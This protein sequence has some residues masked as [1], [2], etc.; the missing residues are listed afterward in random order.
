MKTTYVIAEAGVNHNGSL[1]MALE[2]IDAASEVG[3]DAV[4][5]QTFR[6]DKVAAPYVG[7]ARYQLQDDQPGESQQAMLRALELSE[8]MHDRL[9]EHCRK[10]GIAF[11][12]T[13]FDPD[14]AARLS[15]KY[16]V[17]FLKIASGELTNAP[18]LL[19]VARSKLPAILSTGMST[20]GEVEDALGVLAYGYLDDEGERP[21]PSAQAFRDAYISDEGQRV[22]KSRVTLMHCTTE[23]PAAFEEANLRMMDTLA[24]A[25]Q[26]PV[27]YSDHTPGIAIP[28][29]AA[30]RGAHVLEKHLTLD[31]RLPGPDHA[32]SLEPSELAE[33]IRAIR[34]VDKALGSQVKRP[35]ASEIAN[36]EAVRRSIVAA[37]PIRAGETY[38]V[39]NLTVKR[40][41]RGISPMKYFD[42]L[43]EKA[44]RNYEPDER[45][46]I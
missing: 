14:S 40:S 30:A 27:G 2:L 19:A 21:A 39:H 35:V 8:E 1:R 25:F 4:K 43:G 13:P 17:P 6:A 12:S 41:G 18:L 36:L 28:I 26:L 42:L 23:Y 22:L 32:G 45:I 10:R 31:R 11:M 15:S 46:R 33:M 5:F 20:L 24:C 9:A 7:K 44:N 38:T 3:A 16:A 37:V 29:A 34:S